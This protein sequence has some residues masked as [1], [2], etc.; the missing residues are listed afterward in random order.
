MCSSSIKHPFKI[1][2]HKVWP[3]TS[4]L[5]LRNHCM[6][7][8][9][10]VTFINIYNLSLTP[11]S[12]PQPNILNSSVYIYSITYFVALI[13]ICLMTNNMLFSYAYWQL[14]YLY[15]WINFSI[16][17]LWLICK[18][19]LCILDHILGPINVIVNTFSSL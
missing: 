1:N 16:I 17:F 15:F 11:K 5:S 7:I 18:S 6:N 8:S 19:F 12:V 14:V 13:C 10:V 2:L 4:L 3:P 9:I